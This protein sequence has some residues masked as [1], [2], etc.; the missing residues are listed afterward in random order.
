MSA[1]AEMPADM[2]MCQGD[3]MVAGTRRRSRC[4]RWQC[5]S[6]FPITAHTTSKLA[7]STP[8]RGA[9]CDGT[10]HGRRRASQFCQHMIGV[11]PRS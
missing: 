5:S 6:A 9:G 7:R 4:V 1:L 10:P 8:W 2:Q 11:L 3:T